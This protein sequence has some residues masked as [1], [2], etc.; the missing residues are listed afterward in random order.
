MA[1]HLNDCCCGLIVK[2][3][4]RNL[5]GTMVFD[6][7]EKEQLWYLISGVLNGA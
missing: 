2:Q 4:E 1:N 5:E 7:T 6:M 3:I